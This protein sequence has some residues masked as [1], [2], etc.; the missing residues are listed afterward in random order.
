MKDFVALV[1][2]EC[3]MDKIY[4]SFFDIPDLIVR[5]HYSKKDYEKVIK[6]LKKVKNSYLDLKIE[7]QVMKRMQ[8]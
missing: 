3:V 2:Q 4:F 5:N 7:K 1:K 8:D 6:V